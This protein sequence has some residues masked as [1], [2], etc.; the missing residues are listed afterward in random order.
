MTWN[1]FALRAFGVHED[2]CEACPPRQLDHRVGNEE[3]GEKWLKYCDT[4]CSDFVF[5][6]PSR[7]WRICKGVAER[8]GYRGVSDEA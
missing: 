1:P 7:P 3:C 5:P 2:T 4:R 8:L 6:C